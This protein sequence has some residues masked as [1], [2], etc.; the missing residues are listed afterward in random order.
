M[1]GPNFP[2]ELKA[3]IRHRRNKIEAL[4]HSFAN[5]T[6]VTTH[7]A[8]RE[9]SDKELWKRLFYRVV[10]AGG[11]LP[12]EKM[13]G[14]AA[15]QRDL[16]YENLLSMSEDHNE[17]LN[18][19]NFLLRQY[20]VRYAAGDALKCGKSKAIVKNLKFLHEIGGPKNF[21]NQIGTLEDDYVRV[22]KV[23]DSFSYIGLSGSRDLLIEIGA[24][25]NLI[26]IDTRIINILSVLDIKLPENC[27]SKEKLYR[28]TELLILEEICK[29]L[30]IT[31]ARFDRTL[32]Q[33]YDDILE[34]VTGTT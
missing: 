14:S 5:S 16:E 23:M 6:N 27:T 18:H 20:G 7:G 33:N 29:P 9:M 17:L 8:W 2:H 26:V 24:A 34:N 19:I 25:E 21:F 1:T 30:G 32:F 13:E 22:K 28:K 11:T 4:I 12:I 31:G 10:V 3:I 15:A